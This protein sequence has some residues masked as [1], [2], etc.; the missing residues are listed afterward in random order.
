MTAWRQSL[1]GRRRGAPLTPAQLQQATQMRG[2]AGRS[3][4]TQRRQDRRT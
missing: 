3:R 1:P 4:R 2:D